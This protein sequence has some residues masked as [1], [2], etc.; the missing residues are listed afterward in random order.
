[1]LNCLSLPFCMYFLVGS[2]LSVLSF[3]SSCISM[4]LSSR[5]LANV[6]RIFWSHYSVNKS[7]NRY[8]TLLINSD[9]SHKISSIFCEIR[10][11]LLIGFYLIW[12]LFIGMEKQCGHQ[13]YQY[14]VRNWWLVSRGH[15]QFF[16]LFFRGFLFMQ[17]F[18][19]SISYFSKDVN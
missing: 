15:Q 13:N 2:F 3:S 5:E 19:K 1:M 6:H 8:K 10:Q 7:S 16:I 18:F 11:C 4:M 14:S 17:Q 9:K 12:T